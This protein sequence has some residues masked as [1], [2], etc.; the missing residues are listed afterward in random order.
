M[1]NNRFKTRGLAFKL[2]L[3]ILSGTSLL[4]FV[5]LFYNYHF[6]KRLLFESA[7]ETVEQLTNATV[8][9][10][11][12]VIT[13]VQKAP[14]AMALY[15]QNPDLNEEI[16]SGMLSIGLQNKP[17]LFGACLAF[18]PNSFKPG[19]E[20][21]AP[22]YYRTPD[23][24]QEKNLADDSYKYFNQDWYTL[25]RDS[26]KP[27]WTEPYFDKGGGNTLMST[28]AVPFYGGD[29]LHKVFRG[30]VT[31]DLSLNWLEELMDS[32]KIY[33]TGYAFLV[34]EKW[35]II[36]HPDKKNQFKNLREFVN[37]LSDPEM[38]EKAQQMLKGGKGFLPF[39][40]EI[41]HKSCVLFFSTLPQTNWEMAIVIP[42]DELY[43][44]LQRLYIYTLFIGI[45]GVILLALVVILF[46]SQITKPLRRLTLTANQIGAGNF[47]VV[48]KE[49]RSTREISMLGS[50]LGRMQL[51]LKD[52]IRNLELTTAAK[53]RF[54]SELNIAHDIQQ[55]M[56]PKV[57]PPFPGRKD[58]DIYAL[59]EPA[60][61]V[62]GDL[63]DF[64]FLDDENLCFAVGDVSDKGVPASLMMA[65]TITLFRAKSDISHKINEITES[66][67]R[68]I[69]RENENMLF[70]TFFMGI[71]N[72]RT[73]E[74]EYCNAGHNYPLLMRKNGGLEIL[75]ET[76]GV[77]FGIKEEQVYKSGKIVLGKNETLV[78]YTDGIT[79]A[80]SITG[81][82]Y[83]DDRFADLI[84]GKCKGL[85]T[86]Q[87]TK[88]I[89]DDVQGFTMNPE[90][91][92]DITLLV[93]SYYP[94]VK[95]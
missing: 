21:Y 68:E 55:G 56:I 71:L 47:D 86:R 48:I 26:G 57:F 16:V 6:S 59:L 63:Y 13:T 10:I 58:I 38:L 61:Q 29:S 4:I 82:F 75:E 17:E 67:N 49:D 64:F 89:M 15:L 52:Y 22:Y 50:A 54:E 78:L 39:Q 44:G 27:V 87:I 62:G 24:I 41:N 11:E 5:I 90:R 32:I 35:T 45:A 69:S 43:A 40:S 37:K 73:G 95:K 65:M 36:T 8:N 30:V 14:E 79:E 76:H 66:I 33:Q 91:S 7:G 34:S 28:Y 1:L 72:V 70:V 93:L 42:E 60:R 31:A 53:E 25:A 77:P 23:G 88:A 81:E 84:N 46:S 80:L 85:N 92:D 51:E 19:I 18:A 74:L 20:A 12:S 2:S 94:D 9:R 83:G 3:S